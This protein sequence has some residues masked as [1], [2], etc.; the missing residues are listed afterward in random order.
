MEKLYPNLTELIKN[1][2]DTTETK[3]ALNLIEELKDVQAKGFLS[4][5]Q[6]Y[7][8]T[9]WK[10]PRPRKHYLNNTEQSIIEISKKVLSK[11]SEEEKINLLTSL[12]GVSIAVASSLLT[13]INPKDYGIIDIRVWQLLYLYNEI[14]TKPKGQ[15]FNAEDYKTYLSIL[16]KYSQQFHLN[17]R[18]IERILFFHHKKIQKGNLYK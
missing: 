16:R 9:M 17:V 4:Q 13:I 11:N 15:G 12:Q 2:I 7:N 8:V 3:E 18:D 5:K 1:N 10:S 14:K 6:F